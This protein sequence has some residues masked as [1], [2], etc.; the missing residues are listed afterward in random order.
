MVN[1]DLENI[2][3]KSVLVWLNCRM[4]IRLYVLGKTAKRFISDRCSNR[5]PAE[6]IFRTVTVRV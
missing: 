4:G 6:C 2:L 5:A 1:E 3:K